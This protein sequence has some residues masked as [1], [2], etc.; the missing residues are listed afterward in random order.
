MNHQ[1]IGH[2]GYGTVPVV[3]WHNDVP[4]MIPILNDAEEMKQQ[5]EITCNKLLNFIKNFN[6]IIKNIKITDFVNQDKFCSMNRD[7]TLIMNSIY[8][9]V[10]NQNLNDVELNMDFQLVG[11]YTFILN[12]HEMYFSTTN[13]ITLT[14]NNWN[15][16]LYD[17]IKLIL[18][19]SK[20][21]MNDMSYLRA[22]NRY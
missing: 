19:E 2:D 17:F 22:T 1:L 14:C 16:T 6:G 11:D 13:N 4:V 3:D 12:G 5:Y 21:Y 7:K 9:I 10:L 8:A 15:G 18:D 20:K